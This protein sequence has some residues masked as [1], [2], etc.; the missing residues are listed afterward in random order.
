MPKQLLTGTLD[1]QCD[2]L[3]N[4]AVAKMGEGNYTGA[5]HALKEIVKHQPGYRDAAA[6]LAEVK[7]RQSAQRTLILAA[8]LGGVLFVGFGTLMQVANDW[9]LLALALMG[10]LIGY[11]IGNAVFARR[12]DAAG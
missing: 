6:L 10:A 8:L 7:R 9:V 5:A 2:F 11:G 12:I 3:Y 4:L 1:E